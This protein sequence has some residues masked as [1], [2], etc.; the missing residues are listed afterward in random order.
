[1]L[2]YK[3]CDKFA[4]STTTSNIMLGKPMSFA[5]CRLYKHLPAVQDRLLYCD[6]D[7]IVYVKSA[8][9]ENLPLSNLLGECTSDLM[10]DDYITTWVCC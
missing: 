1:M 6:T 7:S 3:D 2:S 9:A 10:L 5:R 4:M 8:V